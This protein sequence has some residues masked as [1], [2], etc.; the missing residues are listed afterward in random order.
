MIR[1]NISSD[2]RRDNNEEMIIKKLG[3]R[4]RREKAILF[5]TDKRCQKYLFND[6]DN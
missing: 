2:E 3:G 5:H 1:D 6:S 4:E